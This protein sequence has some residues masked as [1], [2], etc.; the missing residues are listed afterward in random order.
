MKPMVWM[1][2]FPEMLIVST[3]LRSSLCLYSST[4]APFTA[5]C[6]RGHVLHTKLYQALFQV[7]CPICSLT[8]HFTLTSLE[9]VMGSQEDVKMNSWEPRVR[10]QQW[11]SKS[12]Y[13]KADVIDM[14]GSCFI[15][16]G[17]VG[18]LASFAS[19]VMYPMLKELW[20]EA[21]KCLS[22]ALRET[23]RFLHH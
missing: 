6:R 21:L 8:I 10:D 23:E 2:T 13:S 15:V 11:Q 17:T 7:V 16:Q 12:T 22:Q 5:A 1:W 4:W 14:A 20:K 18:S 3:L 19:Q 9:N